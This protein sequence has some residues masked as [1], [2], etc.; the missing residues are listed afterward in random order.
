MTVTPPHLRRVRTAELSSS[1]GVHVVASTHPPM[2]TGQDRS[3]SAE[4]W[5]RRAT[6]PHHLLS[7]RLS[8][9]AVLAATTHAAATANSVAGVSGSLPP[10]AEDEVL[11]VPVPSSAAPLVRSA[12]APAAARASCPPL[13]TIAED[14]E[15]PA[16]APLYAPPVLGVVPSPRLRHT[17]LAMGRLVETANEIEETVP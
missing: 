6:V 8:R 10:I 15:L 4:G 1:S 12:A 13:C 3:R 9:A 7:P 2:S 11:L 16:H 5:V 17:L 14:E